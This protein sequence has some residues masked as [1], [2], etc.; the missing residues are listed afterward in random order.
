MACWPPKE[1]NFRE[2]PPSPKK[3]ISPGGTHQASPLTCSINP[4]HQNLARA[5]PQVFLASFCS[6]LLVFT[7]LSHL[8]L[9]ARWL[10]FVT[11]GILAF[12][13]RLWAAG[14]PTQLLGGPQGWVALK[15]GCICHAPNQNGHSKP[16]GARH[17]MGAKT[18]FFF[19]TGVEILS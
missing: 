10:F 3:C 9:G 13:C 12:F 14:M 11:I 18:P 5:C 17:G 4:G 8:G 7:L 19:K 15:I 1:G 16:N 6:W 2:M